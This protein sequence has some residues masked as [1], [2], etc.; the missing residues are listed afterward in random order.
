MGDKTMEAS[1]TADPLPDVWAAICA[2][3][4]EN[5]RLR[6]GPALA[7]VMKEREAKAAHFWKTVAENRRELIQK[8]W[9]YIADLTARVPVIDEEPD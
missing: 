4:K 8:Q 3:Q 1:M 6:N 2:K 5:P 9:D 7:Q